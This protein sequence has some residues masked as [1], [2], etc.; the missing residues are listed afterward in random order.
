[1]PVSKRRKS[2]AKKYVAKT[3]PVPVPVDENHWLVKVHSSHLITLRKDPDFRTMI[4][5][6]RVMNAVAYPLDGVISYK[7]QKTYNHQRF[8]RRAGYALGGYLHE[9]INVVDRFKGRYLG[10]P[11]F[12][13]L[14]VLVVEAEYRKFREHARK[15]RNNIAFHLDDLDEFTSATIETMKPS[16]FTV[17]CGDSMGP[18]NSILYFRNIST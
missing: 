4:K 13:A 2:A 11:A 9:A 1:M 7:E 16:N 15:V 18:I 12:G 3:V 5:L 6:G 10:D 8:F 17:A 14:R